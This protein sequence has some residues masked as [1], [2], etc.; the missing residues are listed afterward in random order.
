MKKLALVAAA[1]AALTGGAAHAY[2]SGTFTNGVVVP[3]VSHNGAADTTAVG[4]ISASATDVYWTFFDVDSNH[5]TDGCFSMTANDFASFVWANESGQGLEG[6]PGYLTFSATGTN[7]SCAN[8]APTIASSTAQILSANAFQV[9]TAAND[10]AVVPVIDGPLTMA[11]DLT[12]LDAGSLTAVGGA[13]DADGT[14]TFRIRYY[15]DGGASTNVVVWS[16]GDQSGQHTVDIYND[17]QQRKSVNFVLSNEEL[18]NFNPATITGLPA[19]FKDGFIE[20]TPTFGADNTHSVFTY[21]V[22]DAPAFGAVQTLLGAYTD[23][24]VVVPQ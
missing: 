5:V 21:S 16:V 23:S 8:P 19:G 4:L 11:G 9:N 12:T 22:I 17:A 1:V 2:T 6:T 3:N 24:G 14:A 20:W 13:A 15:L 10:V 18:D 7:T